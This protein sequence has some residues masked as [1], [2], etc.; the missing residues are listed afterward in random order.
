MI[1]ATIRRYLQ[2]FPDTRVVLRAEDQDMQTLLMSTYPDLKTITATQSHLG[3][4]HSLSA[5]ISALRNWRYAFIALA[6]MPFIQPQTLLALKQAITDRLE[7]HPDNPVIVQP[8]YREQPGHPVGFSQH[9]FDQLQN[10]RGDT[11]AKAIIRSA[12]ESLCRISVAD[13]GVLQDIDQ[14]D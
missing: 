12:G 11:G 13:Q 8:F 5:G 14:P 10:S 3:M 1:C 9:L 4:G 7:Q 6:D 2:V